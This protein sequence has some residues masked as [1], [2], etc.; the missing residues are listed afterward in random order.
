MPR[1]PDR[2]IRGPVARALR[3]ARG[4]RQTDLADLIPGMANSSSIAHIERGARP[5]IPWIGPLAKALDVHPG[6]LTGQI[7]AI[8]ALRD[9]A[10]LTPAQLATDVGITARQL[11]A[12]ERGSTTPAPDV[13]ARIARRLAAHPDAISPPGHHRAAA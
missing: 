10:G 4:L 3:E 12:I 5:G 7:P 13:A 1:W 2:H 6:V 8:A 9:I 11:A